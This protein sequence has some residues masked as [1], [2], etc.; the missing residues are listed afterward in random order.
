MRSRN[1]VDKATLLF[2]VANKT[3]CHAVAQWDIDKA[4]GEMTDITALGLLHAKANATLKT[5]RTGLVCDDSDGA[6]LCVRTVGRA[7]GA[8]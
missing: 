5:F 3:Q 1:V 4:F 7:L 2:I 8:C 6:R